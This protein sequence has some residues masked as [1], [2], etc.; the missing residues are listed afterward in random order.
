MGFPI[1]LPVSFMFMASRS[2]LDADIG[3]HV[4]DLFHRQL[5]RPPLISQVICQLIHPKR[6][7]PRAMFAF[8]SKADITLTCWHYA[9][10]FC[11]G[12][13]LNR[14]NASD[15]VVWWESLKQQMQV[16]N[17][18]VKSLPVHQA[19]FLNAA[20]RCPS[21]TLLARVGGS[22]ANCSR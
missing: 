8:R 10:R 3:S 9:A 12:A 19:D 18:I 20:Q 1:D 14:R 4:D 15:G 7:R 6:R 22:N 17:L 13:C 5:A 2:T 11:S 21:Q 16:K